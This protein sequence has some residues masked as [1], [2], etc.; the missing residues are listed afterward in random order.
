M[1][2]GIATNCTGATLH[3]EIQILNLQPY[4]IQYMFIWT[5]TTNTDETYELFYYLD[6]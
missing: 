6:S 2:S 4:G 5:L 1:V 3:T